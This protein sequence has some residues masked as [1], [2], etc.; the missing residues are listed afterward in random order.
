MRV[1]CSG[2]AGSV[3]KWCLFEARAGEVGGEE[4]ARAS[5][6]DGVWRVALSADGVIG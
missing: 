5:G 1:I 4:V 6:R 3:C 2:P